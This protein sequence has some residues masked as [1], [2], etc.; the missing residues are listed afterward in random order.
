MWLIAWPPSFRFLQ[1]FYQEL[2]CQVFP[3]R[4]EAIHCCLRPSSRL[5][6]AAQKICHPG[7]RKP[8]MYWLYCL[9]L[10][11]WYLH[12]MTIVFELGKVRLYLICC[13]WLINDSSA[14]GPYSPVSDW[15]QY[16]T[17]DGTPCHSIYLSAC[18]SESCESWNQ[19]NHLSLS[20]NDLSP[21]I[22]LSQFIYNTK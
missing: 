11:D 8:S 5:L 14:P 18:C 21:G 7:W 2:N 10:Q 22:L 6:L 4:C 9:E 13:W 16:P 20:D 15:C 3:S 17:Y 12:L 1:S 19:M